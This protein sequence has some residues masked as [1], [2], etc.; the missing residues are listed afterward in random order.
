VENFVNTVVEP[1]AFESDTSKAL[2]RAGFSYDR[3]SRS[4]LASSTSEAGMLQVGQASYDALLVEGRLAASPEMLEG[5]ERAAAAGV[6]VIWVGELPERADGLLDAQARDAAVAALAERLRL[7]VT[8][9]PSVEAIPGAIASAGVTP[10]IGPVDSTGLQ[11]S[12]LHRQISNGDV[13]FL[14]NESYQERSEP[15]RIE[16]AFTD[17]NGF[18]PETGQ[19]V[20]AELEGDVVTVTLSGARGTVLWVTRPPPNSTASP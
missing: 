9:V 3:I 11:L 7:L 15:L 14:F 20:A 1:G 12:V 5:I 16:D 6:P 8:V 13:Y 4:T 10:S 2:R 17:V 19:P 18:D